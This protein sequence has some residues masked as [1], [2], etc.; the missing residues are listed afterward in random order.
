MFNQT[1]YHDIIKKY[2]IHVGNL[3]NNIYVNR[4]ED[5]TKIQT[6]RVPLIYG[7]K[8]KYL[9]RA[10][11]D[12][13][14]D[15]PI[16]MVVPA[17]SFE[18]FDI[19]YDPVRK[20]SRTLK[21]CN[22]DGS[23]YQYSPVPYNFMFRVN[24]MAKNAD[25]ATQIIEQVLPYFAPDWTASLNLIQDPPVSLDVPLSLS[26]VSIDNNYEGPFEQRQMLVW[27]LFLEMK[28]WL[29]GPTRSSKL[30]T[31][32]NVNMNA[33]LSN[34]DKDTTINIRPGLTANGTA[35]SN[36]SLSVDRNT[37]DPNDDYGFIVTFSEG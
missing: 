33:G 2:V 7:P 20:L 14:L 21:I 27:E 26:S 12:A 17:M 30:V 4:Q 25:D 18:M 3:F 34:T 37:I 11:G 9:A 24:I 16:A 5:G 31:D 28:G 19:V 1:F 8:E 36:A 32:I 15:R 22:P 35:T 29:F 10:D 13:A 23:S 6:L